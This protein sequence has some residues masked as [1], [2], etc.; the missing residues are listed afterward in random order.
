[1][2]RIDIKIFD[3]KRKNGHN[4]NSY[5]HRNDHKNNGYYNNN[6]PLVYDNRNLI[7]DLAIEE[8]YGT[9]SRQEEKDLYYNNPNSD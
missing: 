4:G 2:T 8:I 1:M 6:R 9:E 7:I 5:V 3:W